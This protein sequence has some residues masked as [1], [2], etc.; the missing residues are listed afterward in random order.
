MPFKNA[1]KILLI[2]SLVI[3]VVAI[4][5]AFSWRPAKA[6]DAPQSAPPTS[7]PITVIGP[8]GKKVV[9]S[10][11]EEAELENLVICFDSARD[12]L[13]DDPKDKLYS[14]KAEDGS[15]IT[16]TH[17]SLETTLALA[18]MEKGAST[19]PG[20]DELFGTHSGAH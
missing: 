17:E 13:K 15:T 6:A 5:L 18:C 14:F 19:L 3:V 11:A 1:G 10:D 8:D 16:Y 2:G 7:S 9:M 20:F 4:A 12:V